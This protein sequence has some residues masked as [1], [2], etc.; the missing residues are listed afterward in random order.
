MVVILALVPDSEDAHRTRVLNLEQ[1]NISCRAK[2]H[3]QFAQKGV[4]FVRLP[5]REREL[6]EDFGRFSQ[7]LQCVL[8][9]RYISIQQISVK[10]QQITTVPAV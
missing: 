6:L 1:N 3:D 4:V 7:R 5:A 2:W 9:G 10:A 8:R